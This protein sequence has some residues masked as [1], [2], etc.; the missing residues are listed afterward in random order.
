MERILEQYERYSCGGRQLRAP[1]LDSPGNWNVDHGK[2]KARLEFLQRNQRHFMGDDLESL[3][4]KE[5]QRLEVQLDAS[6]KKL[7]FRE[8]QLMNESISELHKQDRALQEQ[9]NLLARKMKEKGKELA[10]TTSWGQHH[11]MNS[12]NC[13]DLTQPLNSLNVSETYQAPGENI[14]AVEETP[15]QNQG[16]SKMELAPWM[17]HCT[18]E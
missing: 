5:L 1:D 2:L 15:R 18:H 6:L 4:L 17:L 8:N 11:N 9:N 16:L 7:R 13:F 10:P 12:S 14:A 3:S